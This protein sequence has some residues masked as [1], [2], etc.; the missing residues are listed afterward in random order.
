MMRYLSALCVFAVA[1]ATLA[2]DD[3][4]TEEGKSSAKFQVIRLE[5]RKFPPPKAGV[6]AFVNNGITMDVIVTPPSKNT[7]GVDFK[8]SKLE[9]F[10]D[11][12]KTNLYAKVKGLFAPPGSDW[13]NE[14]A[15]QYAPDG[16]SITLQ[17]KS[18]VAPGK[19][20]SKLR[21]KATL[22]LKQGSDAKATEKK[23]IAMKAKEEATLGSFKVKVADFNN[24]FSV[25]SS[26]ENIKNIEIYDEKGKEVKA[27]PGRSMQPKGD[28]KEYLYSFYLYQKTS[29]FSVK[30]N[31][32]DKVETVTVPLDLEV[33]LGLE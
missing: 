2:A 8:A 10:T 14:F 20:A 33:G 31:Y 29:K 23:E 3:K 12:K 5:I 1:T 9:S 25:I 11:D 4:K 28:K 15:T 21:V 26:E 32:Y 16:E 27:I 22:A 17:M 30:I 24:A 6:M 7:T 19:G 13:L 18:T